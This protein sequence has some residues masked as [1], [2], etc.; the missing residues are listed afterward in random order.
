MDTLQK[1]SK[2]LEK[3]AKIEQEDIEPYMHILEEQSLAPS[4]SSGAYIDY[5]KM[6]AV[7]RRRAEGARPREQAGL[8]DAVKLELELAEAH[9]KLVK[10]FK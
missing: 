10:A 1:V 7:L 9:A 6:V 5:V 3:I 4:T 2:V 8:L